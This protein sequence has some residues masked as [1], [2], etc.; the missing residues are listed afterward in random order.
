MTTAAASTAAPAPAPILPPVPAPF[1]LWQLHECGFLRGRGRESER[2]VLRGCESEWRAVLRGRECTRVHV[3]LRGRVLLRRGAL[4]LPCLV[5]RSRDIGLKTRRVWPQNRTVGAFG[6]HLEHIGFARYAFHLDL[7]AF[8]SFSLP[9]ANPSATFPPSLESPPPTAPLR[10]SSA[11]RTR[12]SPMPALGPAPAL[13]AVPAASIKPHKL[14]RKGAIRR[15][16]GKDVGKEAKAISRMRATVHADGSEGTEDL[17]E[18]ASSLMDGRALDNVHET[19]D[20]AALLDLSGDPDATIPLPGDAPNEL[21]ASAPP[22]EETAFV[23]SPSSS[24]PAVPDSSV[25]T[26]SSPSSSDTS[27]AAPPTESAIPDEDQRTDHAHSPDAP[28]P[29]APEGST[30]SSASIVERSLTLTQEDPPFGDPRPTI[31]D[32]LRYD[33][34]TQVEVPFDGL[35]SSDTSTLIPGSTASTHGELNQLP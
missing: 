35:A 12:A 4:D 29:T 13:H 23:I 19:Q 15:K 26:L 33:S 24:A 6:G 21:A 34:A 25:L 5:K 7:V 3:R 30:T 16:K 28:M 11:W 8:Y 18:D 14:V 32:H 22:V 27:V 2:A 31:M 9:T 1:S 10:H 20:Q 17:A